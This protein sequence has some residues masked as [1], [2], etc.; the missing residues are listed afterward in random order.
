[1]TNGHLFILQSSWRI[2]IGALGLQFKDTDGTIKRFP[3]QQFWMAMG[4]KYIDPILKLV[5]KRRVSFKS[6]IHLGCIGST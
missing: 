1:M 3:Y 4:E 5:N 6:R 2:P